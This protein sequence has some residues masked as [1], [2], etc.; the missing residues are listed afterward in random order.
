MFTTDSLNVRE[1]RLRER[2]NVLYGQLGA[3]T[4]EVGRLVATTQSRQERLEAVE[5]LH[6]PFEGVTNSLCQECGS[7][8]PCPTVLAVHFGPGQ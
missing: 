1:T 6:R 7:P 4:A 3:L 5:A 2:L 8:F